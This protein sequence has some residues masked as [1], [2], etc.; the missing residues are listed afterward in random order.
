M[1]LDDQ[2]CG[3]AL[4]KEE[5]VVVA[6][7][8]ME[9]DKTKSQM[10]KQKRPEIQRY[11]PRQRL[12][13]PSAEQKVESTSV[14]VKESERLKTVPKSAST[15]KL[16]YKKGPNWDSKSPRNVG[17]S[18][19][20]YQQKANEYDRERKNVTQPI[21]NDTIKMR[22][23]SHIKEKAFKDGGSRQHWQTKRSSFI[24]SPEPA[25]YSR[26]LNRPSSRN[27]RINTPEPEKIFSRPGSRTGTPDFRQGLSDDGKK[28]AIESVVQFMGHK[29]PL[30]KVDLEPLKEVKNVHRY[31]S[32]RIGRQETKEEDELSPTQ[33]LGGGRPPLQPSR[34]GGKIKQENVE[35]IASPPDFSPR[36]PSVRR[37]VA[38]R[39]PSPSTLVP[40]PCSSPSKPRQRGPTSAYNLEQNLQNLSIE[41]EYQPV[42]D[43]IPRTTSLNGFPGDYTLGQ[44]LASES[45]S[46]T[47]TEELW[48]GKTLTFGSSGE[49]QQ[50][51]PNYQEKQYE[52]ELMAMMRQ[53]MYASGQAIQM[54]SPTPRYAPT[55][56]QVYFGDQQRIVQQRQLMS[57]G[58]L[59]PRQQQPFPP[60]QSQLVQSGVF[61]PQ[62][63]DSFSAMSQQSQLVSPGVLSPQQPPFQTMPQQNPIDNQFYQQQTNYNYLPKS[64]TP[65]QLPYGNPGGPYQM[66][67]QQEQFNMQQFYGYPQ[68]YNVGDNSV[69]Q[70]RAT[71]PVKDNQQMLQN[72]AMLRDYMLQQQMMRRGQYTNYGSGHDMGSY[73]VSPKQ[74]EVPP[75]TL[76]QQQSSA[77]YF[78]RDGVQL[79]P[80]TSASMYPLEVARGSSDLNEVASRQVFVPLAGGIDKT[81]QGQRQ[82][83]GRKMSSPDP[84]SQAVYQNTPA[85]VQENN[86]G[87]NRRLSAE[88]ARRRISAELAAIGSWNE[89]VERS[90]RE[91][92]DKHEEPPTSAKKEEIVFIS[93][94][95]RYMK[96][97]QDPQTDPTRGIIVLP[98][99]KPSS[100][101]EITTATNSTRMQSNERT[102]Y[103]PNQ[104]LP[105]SATPGSS[106]GRQDVPGVI[107]SQTVDAQLALGKPAWYSPY[108]KSMRESRCNPY[109]LMDIV[110]YDEELTGLLKSQGP[111]SQRVR[112]LQHFFMNAFLQIIVDDIKFCETENVD[113]HIWKLAFYNVIESIRRKKGEEPET[114]QDYD[115]FLEQIVEEGTQF[116]IHV[117][118]TL[119]EKHNILFEEFIKNPQK[120]QHGMGMAG[121]ALVAGQKAYIALGDLARYKE[122]LLAGTGFY[123]AAKEW[124]TKAQLLNPK[125]GKPYNQLALVA[126]LAK[127]KVDAV[128]FYVRSLMGSN[129]VESAKDTLV[130]LFDENRKRL[131][132]QERKRREEKQATAQPSAPRTPVRQR[133]ESEIRKEI[134]IHPLGGKNSHRAA[135]AGPLGEEKD[136]YTEELKQMPI[137]EV[138]RRLITSFVNY[139]AKLYTKIGMETFREGALMMLKEFEVVVNSNPM[140]ITL[141]RIL[142]MLALNMFSIDNTQLKGV[143][144]NQP[145][146]RSAIQE[147]ALNVSLEM[148]RIL[149]VRFLS[150]LSI[151]ENNEIR[152]NEENTLLAA[153]TVWCDWMVCHS[154]LY[155]PPPMPDMMIGKTDVWT[156]LAKLATILKSEAAKKNAQIYQQ[157]F[158]GSKSVF[159]HED[160]F[161]IGFPPLL[162]ASQDPFFIRPE[163]DINEAIYCARS[164]R[165]LYLCCDFLCSTNPPLLKTVQISPNES[166]YV[167]AVGN[168]D[169]NV[170]VDGDDGNASDVSI[171]GLSDEE[172]KLD[173]SFLTR[174]PPPIGQSL[175]VYQLR[176]K[177]D[178]LEKKFQSQERQKK[179]LKELL[180]NTTCLELEVHPRLLVADTNCFVD[181][182]QQLQQL[183][184]LGPFTLAVPL[185][186][187]KELDCLS[188]RYRGAAN[189]TEHNELISNAAS[190]SLNFLQQRHQ[191]VRCYTTKGTPVQVSSRT[192]SMEEDD[193]ENALNNDDRILSC[194]LNLLKE[195]SYS[196]PSKDKGRKLVRQVVLLTDDR[197]LRVKALASDL[198]VRDV[199]G[200][201]KWAMDQ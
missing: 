5:Q 167:S 78:N 117:L 123:A 35:N 6:G 18:A 143:D 106:S 157:A 190:E 119:E 172:E 149:V 118:K 161:L 200:F 162:R 163:Q 103:D 184:R 17:G 146:Y 22:G 62:H 56:N 144:K 87:T 42:P 189:T 26:S 179:K 31:S 70:Q 39:T 53:Q 131:E 69:G 164:Q 38:S 36:P 63:Q 67:N 150:I 79:Y 11:I 12:E 100:S 97:K 8:K 188:K 133:K 46:T 153:I 121:L 129:P 101:G 134:W 196:G 1:D 64:V 30:P 139:Q 49:A 102:L 174:P 191:H 40:Y 27:T 43:V 168:R 71:S 185:I 9:S 132:A 104:P 13:T 54:T 180:K 58:F 130:S 88:E 145:E 59:S 89:E 194:C 92:I 33:I 86:D 109:T 84:A 105:I 81:Q 177:K 32:R 187:C 48:D 169:E 199:H 114:L 155:C 140:P 110:R 98:K 68:G 116:Y 175:E 45:N 120:K 47:A 82:V 10:Q 111:L 7:H 50:L 156:E 73:Q 95:I 142:Q 21:T 128:Y 138:N 19:P 91:E 159:L 127:R 192:I 41:R 77:Q 76:Y 80:I 44:V 197:N 65:V 137:N 52:L 85:I 198:P 186:V 195:D 122:Q 24:K 51:P 90:E 181:H 93:E 34:N 170:A 160:L 115:K 83:R 125:N 136:P 112:E 173:L 74:A 23:E 176:K 75:Q 152:Q 151:Q 3:S 166:V 14:A 60:Q 182:L 154:S 178:E 37:Q 201:Y 57:P 25:Q 28:S 96:K 16:D 171:D 72:E 113:S 158:P 20:K 148:F 66:D 108:S 2:N 15:G 94:D 4:L 99:T 61:S 183:A 55:P 165:V 193:G 141:D 147:N 124:Y 29:S 135:T 126:M 107:A